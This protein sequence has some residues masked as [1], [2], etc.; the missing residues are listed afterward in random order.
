MARRDEYEADLAGD[1]VQ[2]V[3]AK[4]TSFDASNSQQYLRPQQAAQAAQQTPAGPV[5]RAAQQ[6]TPAASQGPIPSMMSINPMPSRSTQPQQA[7]SL[8]SALP[9]APTE[10]QTSFDQ[11]NSARYLGGGAGQGSAPEPRRA[12]NFTGSLSDFPVGPTTQYRGTGVGEGANQ[13]AMRLEN[14]V[15]EFSNQPK[16]REQAASLGNIAVRPAAQQLDPNANSLESHGTA[17]NIGDGVGTFSQGQAGDAALA[18]GRW[19]RASQIRQETQDQQRVNRALANQSSLDNLTIVADSSRI[20]RNRVEAR[21]ADQAAQRDEATKRASLDQVGV[22]RTAQADSAAQRAAQQ[23]SRRVARL[24]DIQARAFAPGATEADIRAYNVARDP[25]GL[26]AAKRAQLQAETNRANAQAGKYE[27]DAQKASRGGGALP[28]TLQKLEDA[29]VE[30]VGLVDNINGELGRFNK[31]IG[32]GSLQLG[33]L[34]NANSAVRNALGVSDQ[35][36]QNYESFKST[37]EKVRNDSLRLNKGVQTDADAQRAWNELLTNINDPKVVQ[38]RLGEIQR[39]NDQASALKRGLVD[40]RRR[41]Q[42][43]EPLDIDGILAGQ[44]QVRQEQASVDNAAGEQARSQ[45]SSTSPM[46]I[47]SPEDLARV[48]SGTQF[49]GP[50]GVVRTKK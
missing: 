18:M 47:G 12:S 29:D 1:I 24:E 23:D 42:G 44:R 17:R 2:T 49:L 32:D 41:N 45:P 22:A 50:D 4:Q 20:P 43:L 37:L 13:I 46:R 40:N 35:N 7:A 10:R 15:P 48:P 39:L 21:A 27:A 36:S 9:A 3:R 33:P 26:E 25:S 5:S 14:G 19:D 8:S 34:A 28:P 6:I 38:Q 30:A 11:T 31:M 16:A